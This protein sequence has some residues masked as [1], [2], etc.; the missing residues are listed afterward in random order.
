MHCRFVLQ[1]SDNQF[2]FNLK[3]AGNADVILT[4]A[5]YARKESALE[6]IAA[7]RK[8]A[9]SDDRFRRR[10]SRRGQPY[11]VL[12]AHNGEV[13]GRSELYS[14]PAAREEG[15]QTVRAHAPKAHVEDLTAAPDLS[16]SR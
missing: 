3:A 5:R 4:S 1:S 15:I 2:T 14:S 8:Y 10:R 9:H 6:G 16:A 12:K 7:V 11:F 13:I